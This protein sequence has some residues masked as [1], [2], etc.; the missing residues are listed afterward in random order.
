MNRREI[1]AAAGALLTSPALPRPA[2]AQAAARTLKFIPE[3]NLQ[4]PDPIWSTTTVARNFGYM[5]WDTLYGWDGN[6]APKP[7]MCEGHE[8][9]NDGLTWRFRLRTGLKFHDGSPVRSADC[10]ASIQRWMKR[11]GFAQ[12]IEASLNEITIPDE[13]DF[14]LHL[15]KPFP[16]L[17]HG[18]GKPT[19]NVCFIMPERIAKTC[20]L[21]TSRCV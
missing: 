13:R 11:D 20:L 8:V 12:R 3:G 5:I 18:L 14:L 10:V 4:N 6:L 2:I 9:A 7:Q 16:L 21:Y 1:L 17:A 19:A 15:K